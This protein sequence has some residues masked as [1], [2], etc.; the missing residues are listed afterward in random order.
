VA[1]VETTFGAVRGR[2]V[3]RHLSF[4][5]IPFAQPPVGELRFRAPQPLSRWAGVLD[6]GEFR[7]AAMQPASALAARGLASASEDCLYLNVTTPAADGQ[8]RPVMLWVHGGAFTAGSGAAPSVYGGPL[9]E[10]GDVVVVTINYRLGAFGYLLVE[11][12]DANVGQLDQIAALQ[13]TRDNIERFGGDPANVLLF[14]ESAGAA[15]VAALLAMPAAHGLFRCA[16][17]QSGTS[18]AAQRPAHA[19]LVTEAMMR[20]L[21]AESPPALWDVDAARLLDAQERAVADAADLARSRAG[22]RAGRY[23]PVVDGRHLPENPL[24][25]VREGRGPNVPLIIGSNLHEQTLFTGGIP[26]RELDDAR[27]CSLVEAALPD[28]DSAR[29]QHLVDVYRASRRQ[30]GLDAHNQAALSAIQ[31]DARFR[32][33]GIRLAEAQRR[34]QP[35]TYSYLFCY[36]S[37]VRPRFGATHAMEIPFVFGT[38]EAPGLVRD[39]LA[40]DEAERALSRT[41]MQCWLG[42]ARDG[43]PSHEGIGTW[44]TYDEEQRATLVFDTVSRCEVAPFDEERAAWG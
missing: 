14:G 41:M 17:I 4:R 23:A 26:D 2:A 36:R 16:A 19:Q 8:R 37:R 11:G 20:L 30:R 29:A 18:N 28:A 21:G 9:T 35:E 22:A 32:I 44:Q 31:G 38:L 42:F 15:A 7:S 39:L 12:G 40:V 34:H 27:L 25:C 10:T 13:W 43:S 24:R 33:P 3:G 6:A 5:G 1:I